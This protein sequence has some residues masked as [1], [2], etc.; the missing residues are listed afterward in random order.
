MSLLEG[1]ADG[2]IGATYGQPVSPHDHIARPAGGRRVHAHVAARVVATPGP[3]RHR[4]SR[5]DRCTLRRLALAGVL[6][7]AAG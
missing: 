1:F 4:T 5:R 6:R 2:E 3:G 7:V